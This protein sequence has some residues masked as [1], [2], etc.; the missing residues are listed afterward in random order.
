[1]KNIRFV[2]LALFLI[3]LMPVLAIKDYD[4]GGVRVP[5]D[6]IAQE[7]ETKNLSLPVEVYRSYDVKEERGRVVFNIDVGIEGRPPLIVEIAFNWK[8][9]ITMITA[10][11]NNVRVKC[12]LI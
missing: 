10:T 4:C 5:G 8:Q 1:M 9:Q 3:H 6:T 12:A 2:S 7:I 11:R